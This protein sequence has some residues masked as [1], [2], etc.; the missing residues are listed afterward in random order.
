[1]QFPD[2]VSRS[3]LLY[4]G[5]PSISRALCIIISGRYMV[6]QVL[7]NLVPCRD[8]YRLERAMDSRPCHFQCS[9]LQ[10][11]SSGPIADHST[12]QGALVSVSTCIARPSQV[13][14]VSSAGKLVYKSMAMK[15]STQKKRK[16]ILPVDRS[17][18]SHRHP[19]EYYYYMIL[20]LH[21]ALLPAC[22]LCCAVLCC[23]GCGCTRTA[24][25]NILTDP[26]P[27]SVQPSRILNCHVR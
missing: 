8:K 22:R 2:L 19:E 26:V 20:L 14:Y 12:G 25:T 23:N 7:C 11:P 1:M 15:R 27:R 5:S 6:W 9:R 16:T 24:I 13:S 21:T 4:R 17:F 3:Y 10:H 18:G